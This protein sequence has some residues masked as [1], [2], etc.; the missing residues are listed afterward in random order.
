[1]HDTDLPADFGIEGDDIDAEAIMQRI[2]ARLRARRAAAKDLDWEAYA[3]GLYPIPPDA[4]L[5]REACEAIRRVGLDYD[6]V[7]VEE[8]LTETRVPLVGGL[9]HRLR[10][11]L[12]EVV[13]FYV[14]RLAARQIRVNEQAARALAALAR[15][16]E[17]EVRDLQ[18]RVDALEAE[19]E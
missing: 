1:M 16:L 10:A 17:M 14:N 3:D 8:A 5:S 12:H 19:K 9:V 7:S 2:R 6:K 18:A 11:A 4:V 15:D 13:L